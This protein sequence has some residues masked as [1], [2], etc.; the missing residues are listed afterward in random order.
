M[1]KER[2]IERLRSAGLT[3]T[4]QR[5][6]VLEYLEEN[7]S[8]P[9]ADDIFQAV[10]ARHPTIVKATV[11]NTLTALKKV[12]AVHELTIEREAARYETNPL[13][14]PHFLCRVCG[15]LYDVDLPCPIRPG[16]KIEGHQVE[17]VRTY[18]YGTCSSCLEKNES[19]PEKKDA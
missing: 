9:T 18:I 8:H 2:P 7:R 5:V 19:K 14:H 16:D 12:G 1:G 4:P 15:R 13:P 6:A 17:S 10:H 3:P 11:Y